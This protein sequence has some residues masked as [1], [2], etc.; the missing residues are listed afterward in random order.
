MLCAAYVVCAG[1]SD[2]GRVGASGPGA[3]YGADASAGHVRP[4]RGRHP[5][6]FQLL[7]SRVSISFIF[8]IQQDIFLHITVSVNDL[9]SNF[10]II[11]H[12][13]KACIQ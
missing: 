10:P 6:I 3:R 8:I 1:D 4:A 2:R 7:G 12:H 5:G 9:D 11:I 13:H